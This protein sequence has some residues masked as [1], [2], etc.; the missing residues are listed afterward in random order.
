MNKHDEQR[1]RD[2]VKT[3]AKAKEQAEIA[4]LYL[5]TNEGDPEETMNAK[6]V[7]GNIDSALEQLGAAEQ[8]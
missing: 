6:Q 1:R 4:Y 8:S 3:L 2:L 5:V 7:L